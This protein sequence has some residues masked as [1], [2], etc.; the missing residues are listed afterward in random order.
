M[1]KPRPE[2]VQILAGAHTTW[3]RYYSQDLNSHFLI[4][5]EP[6]FPRLYIYLI[7]RSKV[8]EY[9]PQAGSWEGINTV[10]YEVLTRPDAYSSNG[11]TAGPGCLQTQKAAWRTLRRLPR[12]GDIR[13]L[14]GRGRGR[15]NIP[16]RHTMSKGLGE[17]GC[18]PPERGS[19]EGELVREG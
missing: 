6:S 5:T 2:K 17:R 16:G 7:M 15:R 14:A 11:D 9:Q 13:E 8:T 12:G 1:W 18:L 10:P 4:P 19:Q 3:K